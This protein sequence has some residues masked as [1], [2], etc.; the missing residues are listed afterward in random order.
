MACQVTWFTERCG[1]YE[2]TFF[3]VSLLLKVNFIYT[4]VLT[5]RIL[6]AR[7]N[8]LGTKDWFLSVICENTYSCF[9]HAHGGK[10]VTATT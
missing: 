8:L 4:S 6:A 1:N 10:R 7:H 3:A 2:Y 9:Q 5:L